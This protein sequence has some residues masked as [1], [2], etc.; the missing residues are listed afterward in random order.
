MAVRS[1][2]KW[3]T[4]EAV[5]YAERLA[6]EYTCSGNGKNRQTGIMCNAKIDVEDSKQR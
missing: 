4:R 6:Q 3:K 1:G 5:K 2:R